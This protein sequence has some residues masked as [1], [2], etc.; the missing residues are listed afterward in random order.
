MVIRELQ[1]IDAGVIAS[2]TKA[3][4]DYQQITQPADYL[5]KQ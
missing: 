1:N 3:G 4:Q 5:I 2:L